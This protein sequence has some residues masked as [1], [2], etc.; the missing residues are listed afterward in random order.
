MDTWK[1]WKK[2]GT[3]V[4]SMEQLGIP[5]EEAYQWGNTPKGDWRMAGRPVL[6]GAITNERLVQAGYLEISSKYESLHLCD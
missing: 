4:K 1:R 5:Q 6:T 3:R 2:P